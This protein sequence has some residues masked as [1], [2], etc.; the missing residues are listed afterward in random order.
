[1]SERLVEVIVPNHLA[2]AVLEVVDDAGIIPVRH[3]TSGESH[4]LM[5][6]VK[7]ERV[8]AV[9]DPIQ[10]T[11]GSAEGVH[12]FVLP[13]EAVLP[14]DDD[15]PANQED[16][17]LSPIA[18]SGSRISREELYAD[19]S[20]HACVTRVFVAMVVLS[21][22]V[23]TVGLIRD[24]GAIVIGAM[25]MA[26]LLG[27]NMALSLATTLGDRKLAK[28][29]LFTMAIGVCV[30]G[31]VAGVCGVLFGVDTASTEIASR[32]GV[33][34]ADLVVALAAGV[35]GALAFTTG[36]PG[37]LI[38][39][40]VAV[41]I[42]P[43]LVVCAML[44][45]SGHFMESARALLLLLSNVVSINLAGVGTFLLQGVTPRTWWDAERSKRV[46]KRVLAVWIV[47]LLVTAALVILSNV[48][49]QVA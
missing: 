32:T 27:P 8:E 36:I 37:S 13:L 45:V 22:I 41:A 3:D 21:T 44:A 4:L 14:R 35:A 1:M 42:L 7:A 25:V 48:F 5:F 11:L 33:G 2:K 17:E 28:R 31:A 46:T 12:L 47:L 40:M 38:G 43:P 16:V 18:N 6:R 39:V 9:L 19:L 30:A 10:S 15:T 20:E 23:A 34:P 24:N 26:P 49:L 29:A